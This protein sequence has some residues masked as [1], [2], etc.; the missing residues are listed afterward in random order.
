MN[1]RPSPVR[2]LKWLCA[3]LAVALA[4]QV[5]AAQTDR[6][7][8]QE[9]ELIL[10]TGGRLGT[11]DQLQWTGDGSYLLATGDDK[12]VR[13]W[14]YSNGILDTRDRD[15]KDLLPLRWSIWREMRGAIYAMAV[16][17]DGNR[18]AVGGYGM[19]DSTVA[20][21]DR[22]T[23]GVLGMTL[24]QGTEE[25]SFGSVMAVAF[26]A[27]DERLVYGTADGT[28]WL[29]KPSAGRISYR[30]G[31]HEPR[32]NKEFNRVRL[33]RFL[34]NDHL[35][36]VAQS[37]EV[38]RWD[39]SQKG[40]RKTKVLSVVVPDEAGEPSPV[41]R[42][43]LSPDG[44]L[45]AAA[46]G[47]AAVALRSLDGEESREIRL[48]KGQFP[49]S[50]AFDPGGKRLAVGIG[51]VLP[52]DRAP[53]YTEDDDRIVVYDLTAGGPTP[54]VRLAHSWRAERLA[55]HPG[56]RHL[57]VAGGDNHEVKLWDLDNP[58]KASSVMRGA[59]TGVW[60]V[61]LSDDGST[62]G[63]R[64]QRNPASVDPN[65]RGQGSWTTFNLQLRELQ[66][67]KSFQPV[68]NLPES[69]DGWTIEPD[70]ASRFDWYAVNGSLRFRLPLDPDRDE[71]PRCWTF[72]RPKK[73][74][75]TRLA[76][77]H[78][79]GLSIFQ[80]TADGVKRIRWC[81]GHQGDV[82]ALGLAKDGDWLVSASGDQ[83][84]AAWSLADLG[85][86]T[87]DADFTLPDD[88]L[89][90][91]SVT[92][93]GFAWEAGLVE[94]DEVV[95]FV[96]ANQPDPEDQP[97]DKEKW[98]RRLRHPVAGKDHYFELR[99]GAGKAR[100]KL[101]TSCR[102]RPLWR[103]FVTRDNSDWILWMW[104][105]AYYDS[106]TKGDSYLLWHVNS[107]D[108][109]LAGTPTLYKA[110]QF[111]KHFHRPG[112]IDELLDS[113]KPIAV[114]S[115][116]PAEDREPFRFDEKQPPEAK[117]TLGP[118]RPGEDVQARLTITP[119][120]PN[121]DHQPES[122]DLWLND[123]RLEGW[124]KEK[125]AD[126]HKEGRA[127]ALDLPI[128]R[129]KLR[130]GK[131]VVILQTYNG[132]GI[133][134][135]G[136]ATLETEHVAGKGRLLGLMVGIN[137]YGSARPGSRSREK[138]GDLR[139]ARPDAEDM[140]KRWRTQGLYAAAEVAA[141]PEAKADRKNLLAALDKLAKEARPD[142][143]FVLFLAG[144]GVFLP[145]GPEEQTFVFC[146]PRFN[147]NDPE[148]TGLTSDALYKAL[149]R[150]PCRKIV[151]IDACHSAMAADPARLLTPGGQGPTVLVG[152]DRNQKSYEDPD[153]LRHGLFTYAVLEALGDHFEEAATD[154]RLTAKGLYD[155]TRKRMPRLLAA[156]NLKEHEQTPIWYRPPNADDILLATQKAKAPGERIPS[157]E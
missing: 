5:A 81:T 43:E 97:P 51:S 116:L 33:L 102:Q 35:L 24:A 7:D 144:H 20:V 4:V 60:Q 65:D 148:G 111:R 95:K 25:E 54:G 141:L 53:F 76:V 61:G 92:P 46:V 10:E 108:E 99:R 104:R 155:Y 68:G 132:L 22:R 11:C 89:L 57:A 157:K 8:R 88:R 90:V 39:L 28:L 135:D 41:Y 82:V 93:G 119:R 44:R 139:C 74:Q 62:V 87:L 42:A 100:V 112:I 50:V 137:D 151:L 56:G 126:W 109:D 150:F 29:W 114:L 153:N 115:K 118:V 31:R 120:S 18:V 117:I 34:D 6:R 78:Y 110:E 70:P 16:S 149:A 32:G 58:K 130:A 27:G 75:P 48:K 107:A 23:G 134:S 21:I 131:N 52:R 64:T 77:G 133:R 105:N 143:C 73:G 36:S 142:D 152:C 121:P 101:R 69:A 124:T 138:L 13:Q 40:A 98:L 106:S 45:L 26:D 17:R 154:G 128:P 84:I 71:M 80:L 79:W 113:R 94:G 140:A 91:K 14:R 156:M 86:L 38:L 49:R 37:G 9:P 85:P 146:C 103:L 127:L 59:G 72:L 47:E 147:G 122:A 67:V 63:F 30:L 96:F 83:T 15:G 136:V 129:T 145:R 123:F 19:R 3:A 12:V 1:T 66:Q 55:F 125:L 2:F